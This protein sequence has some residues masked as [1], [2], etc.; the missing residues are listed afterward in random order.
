MNLW[1]TRLSVSDLFCI[2][3]SL[4]PVLFAMVDHLYSYGEIENCLIILVIK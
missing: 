2:R 3:M 4:S 1:I